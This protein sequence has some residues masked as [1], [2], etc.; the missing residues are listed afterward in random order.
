MT[1][2]YPNNSDE[3]KNDPVSQQTNGAATAINSPRSQ[4]V[5]NGHVPGP[6]ITTISISYSN[7]ESR[8]TAKYEKEILPS[9]TNTKQRSLSGC[10][11]FEEFEEKTFK[12][13]DSNY[14]SINTLASSTSSIPKFKN[15]HA[16][17]IL[18][19]N[20]FS[21]THYERGYGVVL[22][23]SNGSTEYLI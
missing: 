20:H 5:L 12:L 23:E 9:S 7:Y 16:V 15:T 22:D 4:N 2:E 3:D 10:P 18:N 21:Q 6:N 11:N 1:H 13:K 14:L 19:Q 8:T 17:I